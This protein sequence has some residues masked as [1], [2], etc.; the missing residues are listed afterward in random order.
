VIDLARFTDGS[1]ERLLAALIAAGGDHVPH[2]AL[3]ERVGVPPL[4]LARLL[5][6]LGE[7]GV[8][9]ETMPG[10]GYRLAGPR[11]ALDPARVERAA[12][13]TRRF[14]TA[15]C[16]AAVTSTNDVAAALGDAG[17]P[18]GAVVVAETQTRGRGRAGRS[19]I[20]PPGVGLWCSLLLRPRAAAETVPLLTSAAA[21][22]V[23]RAAD[24]V[25]GVRLL[26]KWPNDVVV[27][28]RAGSAEW[29]KVG[30]ILAEGRTTGG[31]PDF[32][33]IGIG[34]NVG[35][36]P[37]TAPAEVAS[38]AASVAALAGRAVARED[39][40]AA[41]LRALEPLLETVETRGLEPLLPELRA[42]SATIG[43]RVAVETAGR[44]VTGVARDLDAGGALVVAADGAGLTRVV[45]GDAHIQEEV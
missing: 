34:L 41:I 7:G 44:V 37:D 18:D 16:L 40:L 6:E 11:A 26:V 38:R 23:A 30:G 29:L 28:G 15:L 1:R 19:W 2:A 21:L 8:P 25:A 5:A 45:A 33:V 14:G 27:A 24:E 43:R 39:L 31:R 17:A 13:G 12:A 9:L 22:A 42:L 4:R 35:P 32:A 20:S 10:R 3:A 36:L